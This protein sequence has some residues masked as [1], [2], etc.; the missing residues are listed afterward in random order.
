LNF[1]II[2]VV[3]KMKVFIFFAFLASVLEA[4]QAVISRPD[5]VLVQ[6]D[7]LQQKVSNYQSSVQEKI[8]KF[9]ASNGE[10][11]GD[12]FNKSLDVV[13]QNIKSIS[14]SDAG[15]RES[16]A[17]QKQTACITNLVNFIDQIIELS[18]YAISNCI[19]VKDNNSLTG[20]VDFRELLDT[21]EKD[22]N[23]LTQIIVNALIGRNIFTEGSEIVARVQEQLKAKTAE[24]DSVLTALGEQSNGVTDSWDVE[25]SNLKTCF[26]EINSSIKSGIVAVESQITIC[27]KFGGR[28]ARSVPVVPF[29]ATDFFPQLN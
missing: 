6:L 20:C 9:R 15:I 26:V 14:L 22:V 8:Q 19:E 3:I 5:E 29:R 27:T 21:F 12:Y 1:T 17:A 28:G 24:F 13:E 7:E 23:V 4:S 2:F 18:G 11:T 25:V 10:L 16:L